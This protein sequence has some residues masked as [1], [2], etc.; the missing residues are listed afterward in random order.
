MHTQVVSQLESTI[1][2]L[3]ELKARPSLLGACLECPKLKLE[4]D[5]HSLNVKKFEIKLLEKS[6]V[7]VTLSPCE[8]C[9]SLKGRL[10]HATNK[11][12]MLV[13]DVAY[14]TSW[15]ERTKVSEKMIEEDLSRVHECVTRSIHKLDFGYERCEDKCEICTGLCL[16]PLIKM[17]KK[18]YRPNKFHTLQT[19]NH[20]LTRREL[21]SKQPIHSCLILMV[22][23]LACFM[24]V[25]VTWLSF[26]FGA[27][28]WRKGVWTMLETHLKM[29]SLISYLAFLLV[30]LLMLCLTLLLVL[31]LI[32]LIDLTIAHMVLIHER[33]PLCLDTLDMTHVLIVVIVSYVG[34]VFLLDGFTL[35]LS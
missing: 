10:V 24:A 22:F 17:R 32:F 35:T 15:L 20:S 19:Q 29:S 4:F 31:C 34:M 16:A 23:T 28:E 5:A 12:T 18:L 27:R 1:C 21:K 7:S 26:T 13:Q 9:V 25:W 14:L 11:N 33:I 3:D 2:E 30:L 8:L 6:H